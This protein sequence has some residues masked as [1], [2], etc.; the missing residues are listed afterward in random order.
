MCTLYGGEEEAWEKELELQIDF[1][2]PWKWLINAA[3]MAKY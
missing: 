2:Y 3:S 1:L